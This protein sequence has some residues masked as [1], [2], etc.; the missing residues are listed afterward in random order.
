MM[1]LMAGGICSCV[2]CDELFMKYFKGDNNLGGII[3]FEK[4]CTS[5]C[6]YTTGEVGHDLSHK[7]IELHVNSK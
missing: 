2:Y 6:M 4:D 5:H 7:S 3:D 1:V